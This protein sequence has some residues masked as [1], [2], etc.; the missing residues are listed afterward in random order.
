MNLQQ[1]SR[2]KLCTWRMLLGAFFCAISISLF[3]GMVAA[4]PSNK[5]APAHGPMLASLR[6][7]EIRPGAPSESKEWRMAKFRA[8]DRNDQPGQAAA[9]TPTFG[10]PVISGIGGVGFEQS[11]RID[12]NPINGQTNHR[13]Y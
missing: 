12:P 7:Q 3:I 10:N 11:I 8:S 6:L 4:G 13:I 9:N 1:R 5:P 2:R